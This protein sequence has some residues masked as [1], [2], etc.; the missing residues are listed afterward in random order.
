MKQTI[1]TPAQAKYNNSRIS[2]LTLV[3]LSIVNLFFIT[4]AGVYFLFS[5]YLPQL[6]IS[7]GYELATEGGALFLVV[8]VILS[9]IVI[10]PYLV[11]WI[12]S[13]KHVG[14]MIAALVLFSIDSLIFLPD[15]I[16]LLQ[17]GDFTMILDIAIRIWVLVS[18]ALG[19][20]YGFDAKKEREALANAPQ[21][22]EELAAE[23]FFAPVADTGAQRVIT[24]TRKK[25]FVG[26]AAQIILYVG[27]K[28]ACRL[29]NGET[30]SFEIGEG[31]VTLTASI[32]LGTGAGSI[33][34]PAGDAALSYEAVIKSGMMSST[35]V[36]T[37]IL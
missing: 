17:T 24:V 18:L 6:T 37:Q 20:K 33:V 29:K 32:S 21:A 19:V 16:F 4:L 7:I 22:P 35:I 5:A 3:I 31:S 30:A 15:F 27:E 1:T 9:I 12:F 25:S 23:D 26:M 28:E 8:A 10:A 11:L 14:C 2:L 13:K 34:I 36:I